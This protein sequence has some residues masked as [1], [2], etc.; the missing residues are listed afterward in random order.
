MLG[1]AQPRAPGVCPAVCRTVCVPGVQ[2]WG[3]CWPLKPCA[4][5]ACVAATCCVV[6]GGGGWRVLLPA[7]RF[8][9][10]AQAA[11]SRCRGP[12]GLTERKDAL[13]GRGWGGRSLQAAGE[14]LRRVQGWGLWSLGELL[15]D[16]W[17]AEC[18][19]Q[20]WK[21]EVGRRKGRGARPRAP[22]K[23]SLGGTVGPQG[24]EPPRK[25][26]GGG[27]GLWSPGGH[28]AQS[29]LVGGSSGGGNPPQA[30]GGR[31]GGL[32]ALHLSLACGGPAP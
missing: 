9:H 17:Q 32:A 12:R 23:G 30:S 10:A 13:A 31:R 15:G 14:R 20:D 26:L 24:A 25:S 8:R 3:P 29:L 19:V 1:R 27:R 22:C 28:S 11:Q 6:G 21:L 5:R 4:V 7:A 18:G 2:C 16:L